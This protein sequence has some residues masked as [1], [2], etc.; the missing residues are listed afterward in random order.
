[1]LWR[2][3]SFRRSLQGAKTGGTASGM[4]PL[5][6]VRG[7]EAGRRSDAQPGRLC[8]IR[9]WCLL[10]AIA[11]RIVNCPWVFSFLLPR[12]LFFVFS[13]SGP[14]GSAHRRPAIRPSLVETGGTRHPEGTMCSG[15]TQDYRTRES[16]CQGS[17]LGPSF[18]LSASVA[19]LSS[20][21]TSTGRSASAAAAFSRA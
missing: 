8:H 1:M 11:M 12:R 10:P 7:A 14:M 6:G 3:M 2:R 9:E 16:V 5:A 21:M 13:S 18:C 17:R 4:A 20:P 19:S 15:S